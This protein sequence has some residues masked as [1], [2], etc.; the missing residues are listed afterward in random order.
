MKELIGGR[1][2][3]LRFLGEGGASQVHL[4]RDVLDG[5]R[6]LALKG[7]PSSLSE[8]ALSEFRCL[9]SFSYPGIPRAHEL[10]CDQR[11][12]ALF[13]TSEYFEGM[14]FVAAVREFPLEEQLEATAQLLRTLEFLHGRGVVHRDL[15]PANVLVRR[16]AGELRV[17]VIDFGLAT[18]AVETELSGSLPY[19]APELFDRDPATASSDLYSVGMMLYELWVGRH[20][21]EAETA[22][23]WVRAHRE[24]PVELPDDLPIPVSLGRLVLRLLAKDPGDRYPRAAAVLTDLSRLCVQPLPRETE[25]SFRGRIRSFPFARVEIGGDPKSSEAAPDESSND[26]LWWVTGSTREARQELCRRIR[27]ELVATGR[28]PLVVSLGASEPLEELGRQVAQIQQVHE[29]VAH[30]RLDEIVSALTTLPVVLTIENLDRRNPDHESW[31]RPLLRVPV[32]T[33]VSSPEGPDQNPLGKELCVQRSSLHEIKPHRY[34]LTELEGLFPDWLGFE[35]TEELASF[36]DAR[37]GVEESRLVETMTYL[38]D[39]GALRVVQGVAH[40]HL[41][42]VDLAKASSDLVSILQQR[43]DLLS[44]PARRTMTALAVLDAAVSAADLE[45][46]TGRREGF[47]DDL[48]SLVEHGF[49]QRSQGESGELFRVAGGAARDATLSLAPAELIRDL[50]RGAAALLE[51]SSASGEDQVLAR[52]HFRGEPGPA[53]AERMIRAAETLTESNRFAEAIDVL[54]EL[55]A[56]WTVEGEGLARTR[57]V[58]GLALLKLGSAEA[59][60]Q[61]MAQAL[62]L[63]LEEVLADRVRLDL[64]RAMERTGQFAE[65]LDVVR[66]GG[67]S[68]PSL[69]GEA[70]AQRAFLLYRLGRDE[71]AARCCSEADAVLPQVPSRNRIRVHNT[72]GLILF[73]QGRFDEAR[74]HY[75]VAVQ[76]STE[77]GN[78]LWKASAEHNFGQLED[79]CGHLEHALQLFR[80]GQSWLQKYGDRQMA[81]VLATTIGRTLLDLGQIEEAKRELQRA[82]EELDIVSLGPQFQRALS[83]AQAQVAVAEGELD[84][85]AH[86]LSDAR[87]FAEKQGDRRGILVADF[88]S[89]EVLVYQGDEETGSK[90]LQNIRRQ[91]E[92][93]STAELEEYRSARE[94]LFATWLEDQERIDEALDSVPSL[95]SSPKRRADLVEAVVRA[96][97][98][99]GRKDAAAVLLAEELPRLATTDLVAQQALWKSF[100]V[101]ANPASISVTE[102]EQVVRE[103]DQLVAMGH[104]RRRAEATFALGQSLGD[105]ALLQQA[106]QLAVQASHQPLVRRIEAAIEEVGLPDSGAAPLTQGRLRDLEQLKEVTKAIGREVDG[107]RLLRLVL[108]HAVESTNAKRGFL[109]LLKGESMSIP[110]A[111][112]IEAS[113]IENPEFSVSSSVA[114]TTALEGKPYI[115]SDASVDE[116]FRHASS[117]SQLKLQSILCVPLRSRDQVIGAIYVDDPTRIDRF[118]DDD[119]RYLEDLSDHAAIALEK[120]QLLRDN[121]SRQ[122]KLERS[123]REIERLNQELKKQVQDQAQELTVVKESLRATQAE[124]SLKY[125][126]PTIISRSQR[127]QEVLSVIDRVTDSPYPVYLYG[128][129]G[130]GKELIA[131]SLHRNGSR[132]KGPYLP[133]NCANLSPGLAESELF[134]HVK[135]AF[136]GADR[137][138]PG[139][140]ELTDGGILFLDEVGDAS[141]EIQSKL[142]RIIQFGEVLRVGS[143]EPRHVDVRVVSASNKDLQQEVVE[144]RFREDLYFRL[145]VHRVEL[146]PLRERREDVP[147]L[148]EHFQELHGERLGVEPLRFLRGTRELLINYDWPGNVRELENCVIDLLVRFGDRGEVDEANLPPKFHRG[149]PGGAVVAQGQTLKELMDLHEKKLIEAALL[150][151]GGVRSKAARMLGMSERNLYK[152][153]SKYGFLEGPG[154]G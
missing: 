145:I 24:S 75:E 106:Q 137:D 150:K 61:S 22:L 141:L 26:N 46:L 126:Y 33:V 36:L 130:T 104:R 51:Q 84:V 83:T 74:N 88:I 86:H 139:A 62:E 39:C 112:N 48:G 56:G 95:P 91:V 58:R 105:P 99:A 129:S 69:A 7:L 101:A 43:L 50:H 94:L 144:G 10:G 117:I 57:Y 17:M 119:R 127:M 125:D 21:F 76:L 115:A 138:K 78:P 32:P 120:A 60:V 79:E 1:F 18:E 41:Q 100:R 151:C 85:A 136:T 146:P 42:S 133:M 107:E 54:D 128:E 52:H 66:Q 65:A 19:L 132:S 38:L 153:L 37:G 98:A 96:Q 143:D 103:V 49:A 64:A 123:N 97:L 92:A 149:Y 12:G 148:L 147:L 77:A 118:D 44:A 45:V 34:T 30:D 109:I 13:F 25:L 87:R 8:V 31:L 14:D 35:L 2:E 3:P 122:K 90:L 152:K 140:F 73:R 16:S 55:H 15:K 11:T 142:L 47:L 111:R 29:G 27:T 131:R 121:I 81:V 116:R 23:D 59:A 20:P 108:D 71:E 135:G 28:F 82:R 113:D 134:G 70:L 5:D 72:L 63:P 4:V 68:D 114:K 80:G 40:L 6:C 67:W 89:M 110:V 93:Y 53:S 102:R 154:Q 9:T 124:L